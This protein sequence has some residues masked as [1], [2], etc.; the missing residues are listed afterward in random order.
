MNEK[1]IARD[2]FAK[3]YDIAKGIEELDAASKKVI[4]SHF[5]RW[6]RLNHE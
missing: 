2:A 1:E 4:E 6:W 5:E 3:G